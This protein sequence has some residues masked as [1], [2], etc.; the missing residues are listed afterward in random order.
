MPTNTFRRLPDSKRERILAESLEEFAS[1]DYEHASLSAIVARLGIAKGSV[2]Q[3]FA[4]KA[5][6]YCYL[7]ETALETKSTFFAVGRPSGLGLRDELRW[8]YARGAA[9]QREHPLYAR[10]G[11][12][13]AL[14]KSPLP[15]GLYA[16]SASA[17][18]DAFEQRVREA[19]AAGE[20]AP[21][22][23]PRAV[24]SVLAVLLSSPLV[25][26]DAVTEGFSELD[27]PAASER[28]DALLQVLFAG[29]APRDGSLATMTEADS[30]K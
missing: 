11:E 23:E 29:L 10:L 28:F 26:I 9:F 15:Q 19:Q 5:D 17:A 24:A 14:H 16:A 20:V 22:L 21:E 8:T 30:C 13:A 1:R 25:A 27:V 4:N 3:Y 2:Y 18:T 7:L 6:L 12:K